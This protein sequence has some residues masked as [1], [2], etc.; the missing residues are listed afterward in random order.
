[1]VLSRPEFEAAVREA[2]RELALPDGLQHNPLL[3][4]R[5]VMGQPGAETEKAAQPDVLR[6]LLKEVVNEMAAAPRRLKYHRALYHTYF[7]PAQTQSQA[8]ELLDLPFSTYRRHLTTG[9]E[10]VVEVLWQWETGHA[11]K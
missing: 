5:L 2:L 6:S 1:L 8:A 10:Q 4:A 9:I 11:E 3:R 7:Q